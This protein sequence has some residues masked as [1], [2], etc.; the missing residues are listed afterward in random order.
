MFKLR[1][2]PFQARNPGTVILLHA[3]LAYTVVHSARTRDK[4]MQFYHEAQMDNFTDQIDELTDKQKDSLVLTLLAAGLT[5]FVAGIAN[6]IVEE[7]KERRAAKKAKEE[8][9]A[10]KKVVPKKKK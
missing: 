10:K 3:S 8:A 4:V 1:A 9:E 6:L 2:V 5:A 7:I